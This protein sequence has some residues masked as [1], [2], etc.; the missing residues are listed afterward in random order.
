MRS[1]PVS[2]LPPRFKEADDE[3]ALLIIETG[4]TLWEMTEEKHKAKWNATLSKE[5]AEKL[6][7]SREEGRRLGAQEMLE[8]LRDRLGAAEASAIRVAT[9]ESVMQVE[10]EKQVSE[11][12]ATFRKDFELQK[13]TELSDLKA[14]VAAANAR[15]ETIEILK[16]SQD[17]L[18]SQ[19]V[20]L[21][22]ELS[23][24]KITKS[25]HALG[26]M[27]EVEVFEMLND[28][29]LPRFPYAE[30]RD[31]TAVKHVADF[32]L[33]VFGPT[34]NRVKILIDSKKYGRS[35]QM[36]EVEKL[37]S[38]VDAD[39]EAHG[40]MLISLD[41][42]I[43]SKTQFQITRT[44]GGKPCMFLS[45]EKLDDG[46]RKEVLCWAVRALISVVSVHD[47]VNQESFLGEVQMF[48]TDIGASIEDYD[49]CLKASKSLCDS[50]RDA[51]ERLVSRMNGFRVR[52][53]MVTA[54]DV[55][56][57]EEE[58]PRCVAIVGKGDQCKSRRVPGTM[59]CTR[60]AAK[61]ADGK[62]VRKK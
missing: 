19:V 42:P 17:A 8:K 59:L 33:W 30:V 25:S 46:M 58:Y 56:V 41:S 45:F 14:T 20:A 27:G 11:R 23:K 60:H 48:L 49:G 2:R 5:E 50:L 15:E 3:E 39:E 13:I 62:V 28:Y 4:T 43:A 44:G 32:H 34:G 12:L 52:S 47:G 24:Y 9:L 40:G 31:M 57:H 53:G 26:K 54:E 35:V 36:A 7:V 16:N 38:D 21:E 18:R 10:V 29:L 22:L 51:K 37:Y 1:F 55:A 61:E 6:L